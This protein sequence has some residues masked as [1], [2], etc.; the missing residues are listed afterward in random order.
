MKKSTRT[1]L[2]LLFLGAFLIAAPCVILYS[3]GYR[4]D[5]EAR[6]VVK[7]GA[8]FVEPR[9]APVE[10]YIN[11]NLIKRSN[12]VFQ[13]IYTGNLIPR[14]YSVEVKKQNYLSWEKQLL[15]L[16][17]LVTEA[18][19]IYLF[20]D[21]A[22]V[23]KITD[24]ARDF[25][26][27][28][29]REKFAFI[30]ASPIPEISIHSSQNVNDG[31]IIKAPIEFS[32]YKISDVVWSNDS[33]KI[34]FSVSMG[35][36]K[37]WI[38]TDITANP[39]KSVD[40]SRQLSGLKIRKIIWSDNSDGIFFSA[41]DPDRGDLLFSYNFLDQML[42]A[43]LASDV[44]SYVIRDNKAIYISSKLGTIN[45]V[46]LVTREIQQLSSTA[47]PYIEKAINAEMLEYP[48]DSYSIV[49]ADKNV[50]I[51]NKRTAALNKIAGDVESAVASSDGKKLLLIG[52][53]ML[54][55][56]WLEDIHIQPFHDAQDLEI[57][58]AQEQD[59][60]DA[61][62]FTKNNEYILYATKNSIMAIELD[63]RD[64]RN[65][66]ELRD[67][68][69]RKLYYEEGS[70]TLYFLSEDEFYSMSLE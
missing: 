41:S 14:V 49:L 25:Y 3:Q 10:L 12:F 60:I 67:A 22:V 35:R 20:P 30:S 39:L 56:Y 11:K 63:G 31:I 45:S 23:K 66:Y 58:L 26:F 37:K 48:R 62:W 46:D 40:F 70:N 69:A 64:A 34:L 32:G 33:K 7:T 42:S 27:S 4:L 59:I 52:K 68:G 13:N 29:S 5:L 2:F 54:S 1:R 8:I 36:Q 57:I 16:P 50:Y 24:S 21:N 44:L 61:V 19:N 53:N 17:K 15:V 43:P 18:K 55:V 47:I 6:S 28:P 65:I 9:P 51:F 38:A